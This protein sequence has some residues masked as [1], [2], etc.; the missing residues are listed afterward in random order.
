M[1]VSTLIAMADARVGA[2]APVRGAAPDVWRDER[3]V[4]WDI[5]RWERSGESTVDGLS[6]TESSRKEGGC[7][8]SAVWRGV[9]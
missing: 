4:N 5:D 2:R 3:G 1:T 7:V 8:R 9:V 6:W